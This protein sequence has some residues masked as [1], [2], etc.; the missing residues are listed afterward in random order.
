MVGC[1]GG[2]TGVEGH[3]EVDQIEHEC[4]GAQFATCGAE[5]LE[6]QE[7]GVRWDG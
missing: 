7:E 1:C 3:L 2:F 4:E 6:G 5:F